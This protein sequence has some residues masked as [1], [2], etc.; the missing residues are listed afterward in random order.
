MVW[1]LSLSTTKLISRSLTPKVYVCGIRSLIRFGK[2]VGSLAQSVL[3]LHDYTLRLALKLFRGEPAI[4]GFDWHFT[5]IHRSSPGFST[6]VG[7][8]FHE[9]LLPLRPAHG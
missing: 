6:P 4:S 2:L 7:T 8:A 9:I 3:Y 5:A 1:A